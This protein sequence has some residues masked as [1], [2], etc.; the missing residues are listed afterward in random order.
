M[1]AI[2]VRNVYYLLSYAW[3]LLEEADTLAVE[4]EDLPQVSDLLARLLVSG[5]NR[6]L[7]KGVDC[8]YLSQTEIL[9][10]IRGR[11][12][13]GTSSRRLLLLQGKAQC[14]YEEFLPDLLHNKI[15]KASLQS[16]VGLPQ[17]AESQRK[18]VHSVLRRMEGISPLKLTKAHFSRVRLHRNNAH[19]RLLMHVC[20]LLY[21]NLLVNEQT[22]QI[23]F[24][25]LLRDDRQMAKLFEAFVANFYAKESDWD[26]TAQER[27]SWDCPVPSPLLP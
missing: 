11:V 10:T 9:S 13:F 25:D 14:D 26:V 22:G 16:L 20:E 8:G 3:G 6:L 5:T 4:T 27:I 23:T 7:R 12:D 17:L 18:G 2:P 15:L 1:T 21:D 24:R 19:Y